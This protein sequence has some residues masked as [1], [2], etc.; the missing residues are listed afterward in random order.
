MARHFHIDDDEIIQYLN[1]DDS[2]DETILVLD[3]EDQEFLEGDA[4][5]IGTDVI[6]EPPVNDKNSGSDNASAVTSPEPAVPG[7][8]GHRPKRM[9]SAVETMPDTNNSSPSSATGAAP[10]ERPPITFTWR[11]SY[12]PFLF[13]DD[14]KPQ[15]Y[16]QVNM[17]KISDSETLDAMPAPLHIFQAAVQFDKLVEEIL[18]PESIRYMQQKGNTFS[19]EPAEMK[20]FIGMNLVMSYHVL[21]SLR[22]Y[23]STQPDM[24]V[25]YIAQV[26]PLQRFEA[27]R[28]ALHFID[29]NGWHDPD[30]RAWKVRPLI[31]H[32]NAAFQDILS[33]SEEQSIDEHMIKFKGHNIMRQY[34]KGKPIKWGFKMWCRCDARTGYLYQFE[35]YL[36]KKAQHVEHNL[37][38]SVIL[39]LTESLPRTGFFDNFFNFPNLQYILA[40]KDIRACGMVRANRRNMPNCLPIDKNMKRGDISAASSRG[41]A[42][43]KWK[44]SRSVVMLSNFISPI[45]TITVKRRVAGSANKVDVRCPL[46]IQKYNQHMGGVDLMAQTKVTYE[47]DR[48]ARIKYY[49]CIFF[50]LVDISVNNAYIIYLKINE[51][52]HFH[53]TPMKRIEFRA[54]LARS[55][56]SDF[57]C[58]QRSIPTNIQTQRRTQMATN[59]RKPEH[60]MKKTEKRKRCYYCAQNKIENRTDNASFVFLPPDTDSPEEAGWLAFM[61]DP[62]ALMVLGHS[63]MEAILDQMGAF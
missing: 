42:C 28:A 25:P 27:V 11:K 14:K 44:D 9:R 20:A 24:A 35:P 21:P 46:V 41:I 39:H 30:D 45:P 13:R 29:N 15:A 18:V 16:G 58:R 57:S 32:F 33:I 62:V 23:W 47:V 7:P 22:S 61:S 31:V 6:I 60:T 8:S 12:R 49:L 34:V 38:E 26:M 52:Y 63:L 17:D 48:K 55:L 2:G 43:V 36:G 56:I 59:P 53:D 5:E 3:T 51:I 37:G 50:D 54:A 10:E 19:I 1:A 40:E 4:D